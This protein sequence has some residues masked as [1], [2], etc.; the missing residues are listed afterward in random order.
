MTET[1]KFNKW[2]LHTGRYLLGNKEASFR[3]SLR[4]ND[5]PADIFP[6]KIRRKFTRVIGDKFNYLWYFMAKGTTIKS[7]R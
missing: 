7:S 2:S 5:F 6:S 3:N 4:K 1:K